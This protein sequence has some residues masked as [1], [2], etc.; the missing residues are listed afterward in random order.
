VTSQHVPTTA[1]VVGTRSTTFY[2]Q[3]I[4]KVLIDFRRLLSVE[5]VAAAVGAVQY[6]RTHEPS[7]VLPRPGRVGVTQPHENLER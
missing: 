6:V 1:V 3:G 4:D 7:H 2:E 5:A